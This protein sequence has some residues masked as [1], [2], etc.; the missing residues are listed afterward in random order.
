MEPE[1]VVFERTYDA[2]V[3]TVWQAWTDPEQLKKWWGPEGV[4]VPEC[5]I[6]LRV[7]GKFSLVMEAGEALGPVKGTRWPMESEFTTV[8]MPTKLVYTTH[9]WTEGQEDTTGIDQTN[10]LTLSGD[11]DKTSMRLRVVVNKVGPDAGLA[12]KGMQWGFN[13]QF[14]KL[15][16]FLAQ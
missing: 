2:P 1:E 12:I 10:E 3:E 14:D 6:E 8:E 15:T 13:Q 4:S 5:S 9:A 7:G 11:G 16:Q